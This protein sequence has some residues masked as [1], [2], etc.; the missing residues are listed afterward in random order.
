MHNYV[1]KIVVSLAKN[2]AQYTDVQSK[3]HD[4][5]EHKPLT[6]NLAATLER[7]IIRQRFCSQTLCTQLIN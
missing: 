2:S 5:W 6:Y 1:Q 3:L 4:V 7:E